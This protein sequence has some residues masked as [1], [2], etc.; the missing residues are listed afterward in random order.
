M[1][2]GLIKTGQE[3]F[4]PEHQLIEGEFYSLSTL[5]KVLAMFTHQQKHCSVDT[6]PG[7]MPHLVSSLCELGQ[8]GV[9]YNYLRV[10]RAKS[11]VLQFMKVWSL[12][13]LRDSEIEDIQDHKDDFLSCCQALI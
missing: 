6:N 4:N 1:F 8:Y 10:I 13:N 11:L 2:Q 3:K 12:A 7:Y 9:A 5:G